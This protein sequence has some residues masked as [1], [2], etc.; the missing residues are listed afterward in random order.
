MPPCP[1]PCRAPTHAFARTAALTA[2][3]IAAA[4]AP[5]LAERPAAPAR[6]A[7]SA[8]DRGA[9]YGQ[10]LG[11]SLVCPFVHL[12]PAA[13]ELRPSLPG[14][15]REQFE[16]EAKRV[17]LV[18]QKTLACDPRADINRCR[19]LSEKSCSEAIRELGPEGTAV[20]GVLEFRR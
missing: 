18:W 2:L 20:N 9:R 12:L 17:A 3:A 5:A 14:A 7:L 1:M 10:A 13:E 6:E 16:A 4:T 19:V 11:A 8:K 15:D